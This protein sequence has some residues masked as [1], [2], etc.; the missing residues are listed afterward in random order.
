MVNTETLQSQV[1]RGPIGL[2][3][4]PLQLMLFVSAWC[5]CI[6]HTGTMALVNSILPLNRIVDP[7]SRHCSLDQTSCSLLFSL[8]QSKLFLLPP[9]FFLAFPESLFFFHHNLLVLPLLATPLPP[10]SLSFL[11]SGT[12]ESPCSP[13]WTPHSIVFS[14]QSLLVRQA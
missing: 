11:Y 3:F 2:F 6:E 8:L 13:A 1:G 10:S 7:L 12:L 4:Y 14:P 9:L 5:C